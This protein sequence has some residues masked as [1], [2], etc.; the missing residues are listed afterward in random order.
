MVDRHALDHATA[1]GSQLLGLL[2]DTTTRIALAGSVRRRRRQVKDLELVAIPRLYAPPARLALF[3]GAP[4]D[5]SPP[6]QRSRLW[7]RVDELVA[8][9]EL[10]RHP[11]VGERQRAAP[12]GDRYR[13]LIYQGIP[14]DLFTASEATWGAIFLIRTGPADYSREWVTALRRYGLQQ[15]KGQVVEIKSGRQVAVPEERDALALTRW[16]WSEPW[17]R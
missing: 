1:V 8:T 17:E 3:P 14:V 6:P 2:E 5:E 13:K 15:A 7:N 16:P 11:P 12:W 9:G 10:Q 4:Q